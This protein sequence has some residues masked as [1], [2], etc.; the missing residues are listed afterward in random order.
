MVIPSSFLKDWPLSLSAGWVTRGGSSYYP[1]DNRVV[2]CSLLYLVES[3][4]WNSHVRMRTM[5]RFCALRSAGPEPFG[6]AAALDVLVTGASQSRQ[7]GKSESIPLVL[8]GSWEQIPIL[9][10]LITPMKLAMPFHFHKKFCWGTVFATGRRKKMTI[11]EVRGELVM[12]WK[13]KVATK[14]GTIIKIPRKF[15]GYK[16]TTKEE[17]EENEGLKEVWEKMEYVISDSD[18]DLE[19]TARNRNGGNNG[20]SYKSFTACNPKEFDGKGGAIA[21]THWIEKME[22]VFDN[23][24]FQARGHEA[25]I[26]MS[27]NDFRALLIEEF[28]PSNEMEKLENE[29]WNHT[30]VGANHVTYTDMFHE[31]AKLVPHLVTP[32]S[33]HIKRYI[34]GLAPQIRG[35]LRVTQPTT[36]QSAILMAG[37]LTDE[38]PLWDID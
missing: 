33:S 20:Y 6:F 34:N 5:V 24:G 18:S 30:M 28:C 32:E 17:V 21:L 16:L 3:Q 38:A 7:H 25:A 23:S 37:I 14:E 15:R 36:I 8:A 1:V 10:H 29:F 22:S 13:T 31:L 4:P 2:V 35:M 26:G 9:N 11:K 27:W 19:S 12:E